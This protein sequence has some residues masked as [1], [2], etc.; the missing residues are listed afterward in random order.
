MGARTNLI[1][2]M[3]A[4]SSQPSLDG[5]VAGRQ[6]QGLHQASVVPD[7]D[8]SRKSTQHHSRQLDDRIAKLCQ[9]IGKPRIWSNGF[10]RLVIAPHPAAMV[11][12][13][14]SS[15]NYRWTLT[16]LLTSGTRGERSS[17]FRLT[18][19]SVRSRLRQ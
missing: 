15:R 10:V 19:W 17:R 5:A 13:L 7:F 9:A 8:S 2:N 6:Y 11:C 12:P 1:A 16:P 4:G 14:R 18:M 3:P